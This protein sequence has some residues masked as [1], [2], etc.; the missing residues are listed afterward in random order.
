MSL[1]IYFFYFVLVAKGPVLVTV[2]IFICY[3]KKGPVCPI[4][5]ALMDVLLFVLDI[6]DVLLFVL[7]ILDVLD[8]L[9]SLNHHRCYALSVF[10]YIPFF[11]TLPFCLTG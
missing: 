9:L 1:L 5:A 3:N 6:L 10:T 7:D 4:T 8:V 2:D 11:P